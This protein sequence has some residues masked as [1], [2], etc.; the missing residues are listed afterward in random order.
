MISSREFEV[1]NLMTRLKVKLSTGYQDPWPR[2]Y[3]FGQE[4]LMY[5]GHLQFRYQARCSNL[6]MY[7]CIKLKLY[8][9]VIFFYVVNL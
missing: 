4:F 6:L 9:N 7:I 3:I 2:V 5:N 8:L 1:E